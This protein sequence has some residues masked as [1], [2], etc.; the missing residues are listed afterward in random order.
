MGFINQLTSLV[1]PKNCSERVPASAGFQCDSAQGD[2]CSALGIQAWRSVA[3]WGARVPWLELTQNMV[4]Q[5][6]FMEI[7]WG[8]ELWSILMDNNH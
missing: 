6:D 3:L 4:I 8:Y 5:W 7:F 2:Y 1:G